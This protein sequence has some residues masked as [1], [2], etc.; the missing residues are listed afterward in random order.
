MSVESKS[1]KLSM[2]IYLE[3]C[4]GASVLVFDCSDKFE[5][6]CNA[7]NSVFLSQLSSKEKCVSVQR[8]NYGLS[9][10]CYRVFLAILVFSSPKLPKLETFSIFPLTL[11]APHF[12]SCISP[13]LFL[14]FKLTSHP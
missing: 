5:M 11:V 9:E 1:A 8:T 7:S 13:L 14:L 10:L 6:L 4:M 2:E 3:Y 12:D